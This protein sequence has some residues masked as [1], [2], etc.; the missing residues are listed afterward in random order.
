MQPVNSSG[1]FEEVGKNLETMFMEEVWSG[2]GPFLGCLAPGLQAQTK[3]GT[4]NIES[5][6]AK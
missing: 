4:W 3:G 2:E 1:Y 6:V 5:G